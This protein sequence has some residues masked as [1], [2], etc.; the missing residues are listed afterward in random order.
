MDNSKVQAV[1][2]WPTP[3]S[4]RTLRG[5][6]GLTGY[7]RRFIKDFGSI[8]AP[9]TSLL[10]RDAFQWSPDAAAAFSALK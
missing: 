1:S 7:Y 6:L 2:D 4:V 3:R 8:T 5:F 10:K 9:L